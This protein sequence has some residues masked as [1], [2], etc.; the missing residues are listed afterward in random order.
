M[1]RVHAILAACTAALCAGCGVAGGLEID[2]PVTQTPATQPAAAGVSE[3]PTTSGPATIASPGPSPIVPHGLTAI[4]IPATAIA[5]WNHIVWGVTTVDARPSLF[6][7]AMA[8][9]TVTRGPRLPGDTS[10]PGGLAVGAEGIWLIG[11]RR[12]V[13]VDPRSGRTTA[14]SRLQGQPRAILVADGSVFALV[15]RGRSGTLVRLDAATG[16]VTWQAA[17]GGAPAALTTLA[18]SVWV[19]DAGDGVVRQI[20]ETTGRALTTVTMPGRGAPLQITASGGFVWAI[21]ATSVVRIDPAGGV[22]RSS[23]SLGGGRRGITF[24]AGTSAIWALVR[25]PFEPSAVVVR[26]DAATG[27]PVDGDLPAGKAPSALAT[28]D[29]AIWVIDD[30]GAVVRIDPSP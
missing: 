7:I 19:G 13:R 28:G 16:R 11:N 30:A 22:P 4:P 3:T 20:D 17:A 1:T 26:I 21:T 5:W 8:N 10:Y 6:E 23:V 14:V 24:A 2:H 18:G 15:A 25:A 12:L 9:N 27:G 29:N